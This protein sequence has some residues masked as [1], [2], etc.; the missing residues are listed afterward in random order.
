MKFS[1]QEALNVSLG[2]THK[3]IIDDT[4]SH[5]IDVIAIH[6]LED[7]VFTSLTDSNISSGSMASKTLLA[8]GWYFGEISELQ[9]TSGSVIC[10]TQTL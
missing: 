7:T 9:L 8:N 3:H 10:Y 6:A 4:D 1:E 2:Q 5:D